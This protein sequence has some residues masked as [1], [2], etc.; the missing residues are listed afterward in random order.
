MI[1][2]S[3]KSTMAGFKVTP[4]EIS[5]YSFAFRHGWASLEHTQMSWGCKPSTAAPA[6]SLGWAGGGGYLLASVQDVAET[7]N[8]INVMSISMGPKAM[9]TL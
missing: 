1:A 2:K 8:Q 3:T 5:R 6:A 9:Q 7:L 4:L